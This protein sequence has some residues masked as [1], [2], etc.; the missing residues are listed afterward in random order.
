MIRSIAIAVC[1]VLYVSYS[2]CVIAGGAFFSTAE[3][4]DQSSEQII[5]NQEGDLTTMMVRI[6]YTGEAQDFAWVIPVPSTPTISTGSD[7]LFTDLELA[8]RPVF[9]LQRDG[10]GCDADFQT[11]SAPVAMQMSDPVSPNIADL[12]VPGRGER[13]S[14][15]AGGGAL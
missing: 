7:L 14:A 12:G 9:N 10:A 6:R 8:T 3:S 4:V 5:F 2:A 13:L 11:T 15:G 1:C